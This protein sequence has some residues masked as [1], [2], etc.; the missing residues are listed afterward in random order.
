M[1]NI[2]SKKI[3]IL[4]IIVAIWFLAVINR[5]CRQQNSDIIK[6]KTGQKVEDSVQLSEGQKKSIV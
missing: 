6:I 2:N 4:V 1:N 3:I 5:H